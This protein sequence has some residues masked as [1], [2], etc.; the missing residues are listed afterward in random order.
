MATLC[1]DCDTRWP[2]VCDFCKHY[3][4]NGED[5]GGKHG[6]VYVDKGCCMLH[7]LRSDPGDGCEY[8][9]CFRVDNKE[10]NDK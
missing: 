4:F 1:P 10:K 3:Q 8:F 2:W 7:F 6:P 5:H 9:Y